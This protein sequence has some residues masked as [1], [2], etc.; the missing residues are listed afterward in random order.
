M[1]LS[2]SPYKSKK[3]KITKITLQILS[4]IPTRPLA[5]LSKVKVHKFLVLK[6][7]IVLPSAV[8]EFYKVN[9]LLIIT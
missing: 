1:H 6:G 9:L 2:S 7:A 4:K 5:Q 8:T 3:K